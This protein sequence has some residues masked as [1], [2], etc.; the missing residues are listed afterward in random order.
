M[1][2]FTVKSLLFFKKFQKTCLYLL[3]NMRR[4]VMVYIAL[5]CIYYGKTSS[6]MAS[7]EAGYTVQNMAESQYDKVVETNVGRNGLFCKNNGNRQLYRP[8]N[9][10]GDSLQEHRSYKGVLV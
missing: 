7:V 5:I 8:G 9:R 2:I 4:F 6:F 3:K 10:Q 1:N